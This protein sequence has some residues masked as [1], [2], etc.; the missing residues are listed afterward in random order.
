MYPASIK[1]AAIAIVALFS[2]SVI[3]QCAAETR[4]K[5]STPVDTITNGGILAINCE[6]SNMQDSYKVNIF[7]VRDD[8]TEEITTGSDYVSS[9]PLGQRVF[10]SQRTIDGIAVYFLTI[11]DIEERDQGEYFARYQGSQKEIS[12]TSLKIP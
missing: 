10:L 1:M 8:V 5:I 2:L 9:S 7:R 4:V 3:F 12:L 11:V 6:I